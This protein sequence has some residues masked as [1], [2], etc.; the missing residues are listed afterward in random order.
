MSPTR[1]VAQVALLTLLLCA[2][3]R[4]DEQDIPRALLP[5]QGWV[6]WDQ[7]D[8]D[9]PRAYNDYGQPIR[10]WPSRLDLAVTDTGGSWQF[11]VRVF[12]TAWVTLPGSVEHWPQNVRS[13]QQSL[14]VVNRQKTPVVRLS[15]G[16]HQLEGEFQWSEMPQRIR[17]PAAIGLLALQINGEEISSPTW[18]AGGH[19]WLQR[20]NLE[21][22]E[23]DLLSIQVY[24]VIAD[25]IPLWL[26][27]E[28]ELTVS[29]KSREEELG[30]ILP[31]GW[32]LSQVESL[33]PVA[34]DGEGRMKAQVRAGKWQ[35]LINAFR[36]TPLESFGYAPDSQPLTQTELIAFE[37]RPDFRIAELEGGQQV[38]A[39]QTTF[40]ARW[41]NLPIYEW[42]TGEQLKLVEKQ[43][44]M[45][46]Q[47]L[48]G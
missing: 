28:I 38:D 6:L 29:G 14:V 19:L 30:D 15:R 32:E 34:V 33:I 4:T 2:D 44:G 37:A 36:N 43:R 31:A 26:R 41:R 24:R 46:D 12:D 21:A 11:N 16:T 20:A 8:A 47:H 7:E 3:G 45:G 10:V 17:I 42:R 13:G 39:S 23:K 48:A 27:T 18:D 5:W 22:A 25:G 9:S 1:H 40:P 35:I